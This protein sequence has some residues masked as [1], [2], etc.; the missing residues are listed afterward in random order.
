LGSG[1]GVWAGFGAGVEA[2]FGAGVGAGFCAMQKLA[3]KN[4]KKRELT[5]LRT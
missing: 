5:S 4:S 1:S 3:N 2:G